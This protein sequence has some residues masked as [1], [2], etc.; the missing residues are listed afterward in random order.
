M[1]DDVIR[2]LG[3]VALVGG[4]GAFALLCKPSKSHSAVDLSGDRRR[5]IERMKEWEGER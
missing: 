1:T 4:S 3:V 5:E 2:L